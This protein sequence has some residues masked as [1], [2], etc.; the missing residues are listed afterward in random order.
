MKLYHHP[1]TRAANVV[2]MLE[3]AG[4]PYQLEYVDIR[5]GAQ[6]DEAFLALNPMGKL[7]T[8]VDGEVVLT[9]S[10]AI[11]LYL[12][13]RADGM[14]PAI[15]DPRR[16]AYYRWILFGPSVVEPCAYAKGANWEYQPGSAGWGTFEAMHATLEHAIGEGPWLLGDTFTMADV[17]LGG[18]IRYMVQFGMVEKR[19]RFMDYL[20]RLQ[21]RPAFQRSTA[22]NGR[23]IEERGLGG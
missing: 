8:L 6:K 10:A 23:I 12:G 18:T 7:P 21:Q 4:L 13:D 3:E 1:F 11:G 9:E 22:I 5:A 20:D 2:W 19:E 16:A 15:D 14:A 17:C